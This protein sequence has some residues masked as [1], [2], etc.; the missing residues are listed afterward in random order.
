M[1]RKPK[2]ETAPAADPIDMLS[3]IDQDAPEGATE[4]VIVPDEAPPTP[5]VIAQRAASIVLLHPERFDQFYDK[6]ADRMA[7]FVPDTSTPASRAAI[8]SK[9]FEVT[10]LKTSLDKAGL[11]LT[12]GWRTQTKVVNDARKPMVERLNALAD[13]VRKPLTDWENAE[14][15]RT[16][17]NDATLLEIRTAAQVVEGDTADGVAERGRRIYLMTFKAP[18]WSEDEA[19]EAIGAQQATVQALVSVRDRLKQ[20][21]ADR[22]EL[23][24]LRAKNEARE[25]RDRQ[26]AEARDLAG[27]IVE[28]QR[29]YDAAADKVD[30]TIV[31][32]AVEEAGLPADLVGVATEAAA[33]LWL[34]HVEARRVRLEN[35]ARELEEQRQRDIEA[36]AERER[37]AEAQRERDRQD[38]ADNARREAEEAAAT[39]Q[40]ERDAQ[41]A[42]ELKEANDERDRVAKVAKDAEDARQRE[43]EQRE[44][45]AQAERDRV[46]AERVRIANEQAEAAEVE[47]KRQENAEHR[48]AV[49]GE[50]ADDIMAAAAIEDRELVRKVVLAIAAGNVRHCAVSF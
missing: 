23:A 41:H 20:E 5:A 38:A 36:A 4:L 21:E 44:R 19:A 32:T 40:A 48:R 13:Q 25:L 16:A 47:R 17:A 39:A 37:E 35:E 7:E 26:T 49:M 46:E 29:N 8:A 1:A 28:C 3:L 42:R 18:Q 12:E 9:A 24:E 34:D 11:G 14:A 31:A 10:K 27:G 45:D 2:A 15:I 30:P 33:G 22:A 6:I 43:A 50:V